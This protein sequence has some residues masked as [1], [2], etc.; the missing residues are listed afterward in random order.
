M[1]SFT[2]RSLCKSS[3]LS[4]HRCQKFHLGPEG[5]LV[6]LQYFAVAKEVFNVGHK[7]VNNDNSHDEL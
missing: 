3:L 4:S 1:K 2:L 6:L 7:W 5:I